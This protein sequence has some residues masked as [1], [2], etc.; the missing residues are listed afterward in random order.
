MRC[1][2]LLKMLFQSLR[3][4]IFK[5]RRSCDSP[6]SPND[7]SENFFIGTATRYRTQCCP[8]WRPVLLRVSNCQR[9]TPVSH[10]LSSVFL[11]KAP[12]MR[13]C[14][15]LQLSHLIH[16]EINLIADHILH[17]EKDLL[18]QNDKLVS[19]EVVECL[20]L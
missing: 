9:T 2:V 10:F 12:T 13:I 19:C 14:D 1:W 20:F 4:T 7:N 17:T 5:S 3:C 11:F 16:P 8:R 15:K 6:I 18:P